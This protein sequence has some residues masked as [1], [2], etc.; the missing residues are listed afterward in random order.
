[1]KCLLCKGSFDETRRPRIPC[2]Q[3]LLNSPGQPALEQAARSYEHPSKRQAS[4]L[5]KEA[6]LVLAEGYTEAFGQF[7][8]EM[9]NLGFDETPSYDRW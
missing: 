6:S 7:L 5:R 2:L 9:R 1:M 4:C 3:P 8:D